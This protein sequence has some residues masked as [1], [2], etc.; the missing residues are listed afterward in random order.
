MAPDSTNAVQ[1]PKCFDVRHHL[2]NKQLSGC[3][4]WSQSWAQASKLVPASYTNVC[5]GLNSHRAE[6]RGNFELLHNFFSLHMGF[7]P[8]AA[9]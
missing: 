6:A 5:L 4:S 3:Y 8:T 7:I 9:E 1:K 2:R